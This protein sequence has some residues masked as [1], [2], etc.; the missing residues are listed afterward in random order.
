[1]KKKVLRYQ[2]DQCVFTR[3]TYGDNAGKI[4]ERYLYKIKEIGPKQATL[5][6][7]DPVTLEVRG[8]PFHY[9]LST[10]DEAKRRQEYFAS[11]GSSSP[12]ELLPWKWSHILVLLGEEGWDPDSNL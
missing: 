11:L 9:R 5:F 10:E 6:R 3:F 7:I 4:D 1:M 12:K 2:K 8:R